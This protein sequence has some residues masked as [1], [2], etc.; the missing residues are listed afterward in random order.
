MKNTNKGDI[1]IMHHQTLM[2]VFLCLLTTVTLSSCM[3]H[4]QANL[5][6]LVP[7]SSGTNGQFCNLQGPNKQ[8]KVLVA[9]K[10]QGNANA[11]KSV[12]TVQFNT[13]PVSAPIPLQTPPI[14]AGGISPTMSVFVPDNCGVPNCYAT[15]T[16]DSTNAVKEPNKRTLTCL[17][18]I[19]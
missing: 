14:L 3:P 15:I 10:N 6:D 4:P 18:R 7:V 13:V 11:P 8:L 2:L 16:V 5:P 9:V 1:L 12:T 19:G 17:A